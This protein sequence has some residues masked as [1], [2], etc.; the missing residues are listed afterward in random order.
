MIVFNK[1]AYEKL[2]YAP[3]PVQSIIPTAAE[4]ASDWFISS[5]EF[6]DKAGGS[7]SSS[8]KPVKRDKIKSRVC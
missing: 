2:F 6:I 7:N 4:K 3:T 8:Y 5:L 1:L